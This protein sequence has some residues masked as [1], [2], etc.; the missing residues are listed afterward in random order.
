MSV[1]SGIY[2]RGSVSAVVSSV[3]GLHVVVPEASYPFCVISPSCANGSMSVSILQ[4][5]GKRV[6]G[7]LESYTSSSLS[8]S[9]SFSSRSGLRPAIVNC[10]GQEKSDV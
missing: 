1:A 10:A 8:S 4:C 2:I 6:K 9:W 3:G 5:G 7:R